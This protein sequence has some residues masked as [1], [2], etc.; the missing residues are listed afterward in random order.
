MTISPDSAGLFSAKTVTL[1][2]L[3]VVSSA[4]SSY[5]VNFGVGSAMPA[6]RVSSTQ[7]SVTTPVISQTTFDAQRGSNLELQTQVT[8]VAATNTYAQSSSNAFMFYNCNVYKTDCA[9]CTDSFAP[10]PRKQDCSFC[11]DTASCVFTVNKTVSCSTSGSCPSEYITSNNGARV[12]LTMHRN[13]ERDSF[14]IPHSK[15]RYYHVVSR[16]G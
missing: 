8:V 9:S 14:N 4:V 12:F 16:G 1:T 13:I 6:T 10:N 15:S 5:T 2:I 11:F 7:L 3:P